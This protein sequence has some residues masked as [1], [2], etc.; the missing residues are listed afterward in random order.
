MGHRLGRVFS[1]SEVQ[2]RRVLTTNERVKAFASAACGEELLAEAFGVAFGFG[3]L[4]AGAIDGGVGQAQ[5]HPPDHPE[6]QR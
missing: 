6:H 2:H 3:I 1:F 5:N 4:F